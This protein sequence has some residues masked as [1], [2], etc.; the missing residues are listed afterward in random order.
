LF[1]VPRW[2]ERDKK[3]CEKNN[4]PV[5]VPGKAGICLILQGL[6]FEHNPREIGFAV[7]RASAEIGQK[8]LFGTDTI[9]YIRSLY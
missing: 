1:D 4:H 3:A 2:K 7:H 5:E 9:E 8:D 6:F